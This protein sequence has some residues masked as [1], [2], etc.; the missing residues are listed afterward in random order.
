MLHNRFR[1]QGLALDAPYPSIDGEA[2][3]HLLVR[4]PVHAATPLVDA[5]GLARR[6]GVAS[7]HVKDERGRM[8]LGS[9]KALGAAYVIARDAAGGQASGRGYVTAS[10][11]NH[12]LSVAAGARVFGAQSIVYLARTVPEG[13]ADR[14]RAQGAE[15]RRAGADYA[16]SMAAAETAAH[17]EGLVLLS[18]SS[19]AGYSEIP[20][21]LME[22][23]LV[24]AAE[25]AEQMPWPPTHILLQAG[26]GGLA[27][28][29]AAHARHVWG[30]API[31]VVV[32][33]EAAPALHD[34]IAAG[35][36]VD[37][38]GPASCMGRLDCKRASWIALRGLSRDA[39]GF[40]LLSEG[41]AQAAMPVLARA[42]LATTPSGGAGLAALL[43]GLDLPADARVIAILS[44]AP[45]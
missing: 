28:A 40:A 25:A 21:R 12:G 38:Q 34:A 33:P 29:V 8:G 42:G 6:A 18:D 10:A 1:G 11:G 26:V 41:Q 14:L 3:R 20:H 9:F 27:G 32:E 31:I 44:E 7:L 24:L 22:G 19:W 13:F 37:A 45:E 30:E 23:Y 4:C 2:P 35:K 39:D 17:D 5:P 36:S 43:A 15:V 16:A